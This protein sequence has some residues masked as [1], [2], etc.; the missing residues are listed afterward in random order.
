MWSVFIFLLSKKK[1]QKKVLLGKLVGDH[2]LQ[3]GI[4]KIYSFGSTFVKVKIG[5]II[6]LKPYH[7]HTT[8]YTSRGHHYLM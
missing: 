2:M 4:K 5:K 1:A 8:T 7:L 3:S 6:F